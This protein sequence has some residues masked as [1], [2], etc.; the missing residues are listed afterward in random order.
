LR[1]YEFEGKEL[2]DRHSIPT[3]KRNL[4]VDAESAVEMSRDTGFPAV[5][6]AQVLTGG[7]GKAGGVKI[8][9]DEKETLK[10]A[11]ELFGRKISGFPV[12]KL[13]VEERLDVEREL[14][15][16]VSIDRARNCLAVVT[17]PEGGVDV[18]EI[19]GTCPEK[20]ARIDLKVTEEFSSRQAFFLSN[21]LG[22]ENSVL[23]TVSGIILALVGLFRKHE[24]KLAE[25][26]PLVLTRKGRIVAADARVSIDDDALFR[27]PELSAMGIEKRHEEGEFTDREK[28]AKED[29][30]PYVDLDGDI[31][32]LP[33]GAGFGIMAIDLINFYG[34]K[35]ANFMDSGGGPSPQ[36][37]AGMLSLLEDNPNVAGIFGARFGGISRCDDFAR[38]VVTFLREKG[39]SKPMVMRMTGSMWKEGVRVFE[40]ARRENPELFANVEIHGI[41]TPIE[42]VAKRAVQLVRRDNGESGFGHSD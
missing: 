27:H 39:P 3:P 25:I 1:L 8:V 29:G 13:L 22:L 42:E 34:G 6:K 18:E 33:G 16:G 36:R 40:D 9:S 19:A 26:N 28:K 15:A 20:I 14:Y 2:F 5:L 23:K 24:A 12:E 38:G 31:G 10:Q 11:E 21:A 41:Q 7:R 32:M 30:I 37:L 4:A 35:P 17:C